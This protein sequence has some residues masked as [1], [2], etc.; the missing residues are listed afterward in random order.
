LPAPILFR[1]ASATTL[2][3]VFALALAGAA[4]QWNTAKDN[5]LRFISALDLLIADVGAGDTADAGGV[6]SDTVMLVNIHISSK[7]V[8]AVSFS[9]DDNQTHSYGP[10]HTET[11]L[12]SAHAFGGPKCLVKEIQ[13]LSGLAINRFIAIDFAG[14]AKMVEAVHLAHNATSRFYRR[15]SALPTPPTSTCE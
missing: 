12:N 15:I 11:K 8:V 9:R 2:V 6:R 4:W 14:F 5:R 13:K 10:A 3:S 1:R 7:R